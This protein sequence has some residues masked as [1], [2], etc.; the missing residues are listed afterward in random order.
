MTWG[1]GGPPLGRCREGVSFACCL[2]VVW[3]IYRIQILDDAAG[4]L[5]RITQAGQYAIDEPALG[6][7]EIQV[8]LAMHQCV[9]GLFQ[10]HRCLV[11]SLYRH[12]LGG[13]Q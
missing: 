11:R 4:L 2:F 7:I 6:T 12:R 3:W 8:L 13:Q 1:T 5:I 10:I 9:Y